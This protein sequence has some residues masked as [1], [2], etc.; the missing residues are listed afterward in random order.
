[1]L[2]MLRDP[3]TGDVDVHATITLIGPENG[4]GKFGILRHQWGQIVSIG[5]SYVTLTGGY[6]FQKFAIAL[7]NAWLIGHPC[8]HDALRAFFT[9]GLDHGGDQ[10]LSVDFF[11]GAEAE[12]AVPFGLPEGLVG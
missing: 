9:Q 2:G 7:K 12:F 4:D 5:D 10:R 8:P 11:G 3:S 1:M 6:R